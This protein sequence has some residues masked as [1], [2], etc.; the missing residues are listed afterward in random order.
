MNMPVI[1]HYSALKDYKMMDSGYRP[2]V[3]EKT[4]KLPQQHGDGVGAAMGA[5][6]GLSM[7]ADFFEQRQRRP[8]EEQLRTQ[9]GMT[10]QRYAPQQ[11]TNP[12]GN[13]MTNGG[14]GQV[15]PSYE[16]GGV[17][18]MTDD[19]LTQY[20]ANGGSVEFVD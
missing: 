6:N 12:Y 7:A 17:Y 8:Y 10:D 19:E 15:M 11:Q 20:M 14:L 9:M 18:D 4:E 16:E 2:P 3:K 13:Y 5:I 1:P